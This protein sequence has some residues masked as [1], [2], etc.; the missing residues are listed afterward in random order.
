[1]YGN[2]ILTSPEFW[3]VLACGFLLGLAAAFGL[4]AY[5]GFLDEQESKPEV[6]R[7]SNDPGANKAYLERCA[8]EARHPAAND[9]ALDLRDA[10]PRART[11][12]SEM[13]GGP[14]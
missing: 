2:N 7:R 1:M 8:R 11:A 6:E 12:R 9:A 14:R 5:L 13:R 4:L 10:Y 3:G